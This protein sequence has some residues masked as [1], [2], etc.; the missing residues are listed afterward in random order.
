MGYRLFSQRQVEEQALNAP[1]TTKE[2]SARLH[3]QIISTISEAIGV[4]YDGPY[5]IG[6][7]EIETTAIWN[8][9][10][11]ILFKQCD[12]YAQTPHYQP[13]N[14]IRD[15]MQRASDADFLDALDLAVALIATRSPE[16]WRRGTQYQRH[17]H[18]QISP[19]DALAE[20]DRWLRE[21]GSAYRVGRGEIIYSTD[22]FTHDEI[23]LPALHR[24]SEQGFENAAREFNDAL[25]AYKNGR[26]AD[27]LT[28]A[29]HSF[30]STMKVIAGK[31]K[32]TYEPTGTAK[33]LI[34]V[35]LDNGLFSK[36]RQS[37][38]SHLQGLLTSEVP[39]L[40]NKTPSAGAWGG[41]IYGC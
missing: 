1:P 34:S 26:F 37:A 15:F 2:F 27:V 6:Q 3:R 36:A 9:F 30:E 11:R 22:D 18:V 21:S 29:N 10:D 40:R 35:M 14:R 32:W 24:L 19:G 13:D 23:V 31:M 16:I 39:T 17:C 20:I 8:E 25:V 41:R 5:G 38:L 33:H 7:K 12:A 4:Y 28:K